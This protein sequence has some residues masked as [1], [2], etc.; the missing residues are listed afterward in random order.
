MKIFLRVLFFAVLLLGRDAFAASA[1]DIEIRQRNST[2]T[3]WEQKFI[4][5]SSGKI[6]GFTTS[7]VPAAIT[8]GTNL[9]FDSGTN[10]LSASGGSSG[11]AVDTVAA[12]KALSVTGRTTGDLLTLRG[13]YATN[14]GGQGTFV[15][16]SSST[17]SEDTGLVVQPTT[18]SGRWLR[19]HTGVVNVKWFGAKGDGTTADWVPLQSALNAA[20]AGGYAYGTEGY[21]NRISTVIIPPGVYAVGAT[22]SLNA[23]QNVK[24]IGQKATLRASS[25]VPTL[26]IGT[27]AN[28][29][30]NIEIEGLRLDANSVGTYG[31]YVRQGVFLTIRNV[32]ASNYSL[33]GFYMDGADNRA[34]Y[35][36]LFDSC[37]Y[38]GPSGNGWVFT[39]SG[40]T[41]AFTHF[42]LQNCTVEGASYGI[43]STG[44]QV[45]NIIGGVYEN[46]TSA[47]LL[48]NGGR[49][50]LTGTFFENG[51]DGA[52][53]IATVNAFVVPINAA[54]SP[55]AISVSGT[56]GVMLHQIGPIVS[57]TDGNRF[58]E[59]YAGEY[60]A[61]PGRVMRMGN[62]RTLN[63]LDTML[64]HNLVPHHGSDDYKTHKTGSYAAMEF[65][66]DGST[67]RGVRWFTSTSN[68]TAGSP[69]SLTPKMTLDS[70]GN[71]TVVGNITGANLSGTIGNVTANGTLTGNTTEGN[72][73]IGAGG[74]SAR[75]SAIGYN[76]TTN[77]ISVNAVSSNNITANNIVLGNV[78]AGDVGGTGVDNG[79]RTLSFAGNVTISGAFNPN[80]I[81]T[82]SVNST[83][84]EI[85]AAL[86]FRGIPW[87]VAN[88]NL[89]TNATHNGKGL[90][91]DGLSNNTTTITVNR[92]QAATDA[93]N[94]GFTTSFFNASTGN[95]LTVTA[96]SGNII[97][98][99]SGNLTGGASAI[100]APGGLVTI[101]L[102][103]STLIAAGTNVTVP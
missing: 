67:A 66:Y 29:P 78:I 30:E 74:T 39:Q 18:G 3:Q 6:F 65:Y 58:G 70:G 81:V 98:A 68:G 36:V 88:A 56:G 59:V 80:I 94:G 11:L 44:N 48:V 13:F 27:N 63:Y 31:L 53:D 7:G 86:G 43:S 100:I 92:T 51:N 5:G 45:I 82:G 102:A 12:L 20:T 47:C 54:F 2:N 14:D 34:T 17:A 19:L 69:M 38:S 103:N 1:Y 87:V 22:L 76:I 49:A 57:D 35:S 101:T 91:A 37:V 90:I 26:Q 84:P 79:N 46:V 64:S 93:G 77:T 15:Y 52:V 85:N 71:L 24:I 16:N 72:I 96:S 95:N 32:Q 83:L 42:T 40:N 62:S 25:A 75:A 41:S 4:T 8:L 28:S 55:G 33:A 60:T 21:A 9:T 97:L 89:T 23:G 99:G 50:T 10:T 61:S 73:L